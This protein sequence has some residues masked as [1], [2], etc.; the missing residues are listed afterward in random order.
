MKSRVSLTGSMEP[1]ADP[2]D[3][4]LRDLLEK[5]GALLRRTIAQVCRAGSGLSVDDIEQ[6]ARVRLWRALQSER[7][8]THPRSYIYKV[9]LSATLRAIRQVKARRETPLVEEHEVGDAGA[10]E[11]L[12]ASPEASPE[13]IAER[14]EWMRKVDAAMAHLAENRRLAVRLHLQGLTTTEI[15][16]L[17]GWTEPK[18]RNLVH[19]GL[20]DLRAFLRSEG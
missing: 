19:R 1:P 4:R 10:A 13:A 16:D 7:E 17:L 6:D 8:I 9:A 18:A 15:G 5:Y 12:Q 2:A 20:I 3:A 14:R 11:I